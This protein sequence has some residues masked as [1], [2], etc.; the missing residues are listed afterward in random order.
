MLPTTIE[1]T[2]STIKITDDGADVH[3]F[4]Q[5]FSGQMMF[6]AGHRNTNTKS[7]FNS[8]SIDGVDSLGDQGFFLPFTDSDF[9]GADGRF[10]THPL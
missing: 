2:G 5:T 8:I 7:D 1:R 6:I 3:T 9:I 4:T 10:S